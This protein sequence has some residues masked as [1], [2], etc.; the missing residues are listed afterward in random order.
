MHALINIEPVGWF[1][2][3]PAPKNQEILQATHLA[4]P[5]PNF[6]ALTNLE[7]TRLRV[8][9]PLSK[10]TVTRYPITASKPPQLTDCT[11]TDVTKK[12]H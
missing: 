12:A 9:F 7:T 11:A 2:L 8:L 6:S 3:K 5:F 10:V 1:A 4:D